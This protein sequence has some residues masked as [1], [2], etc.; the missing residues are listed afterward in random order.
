MGYL[1]VGEVSI[2]VLGS[3]LIAESLL[4]FMFHSILTF[5]FD[6]ILGSF[7]KLFGPNKL[8]EAY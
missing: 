5:N 4:P 2:I 1:W 6:L 8:F 7:L 3:T